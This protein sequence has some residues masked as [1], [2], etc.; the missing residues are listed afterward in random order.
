MIVQGE[1]VRIIAFFG[2]AYDAGT[3]VSTRERIG[4]GTT[5]ERHRES[6]A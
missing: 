5:T 6:M 4:T 2:G 3:D 1:L